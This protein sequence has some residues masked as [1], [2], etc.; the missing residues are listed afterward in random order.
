MS[1]KTAFE[2]LCEMA[3]EYA[4]RQRRP[5]GTETRFKK[6]LKMD[7]VDFLDLVLRV[8]K[9][10]CCRLDDEML[11]QVVTLG[12]LGL[13]LEK[14]LEQKEKVRNEDEGSL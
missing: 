3:G 14:A 5:I 1:E 9:R 11:A 2:V 12:Q 13:L 10:F 6:D 8:E 7:A 4:P